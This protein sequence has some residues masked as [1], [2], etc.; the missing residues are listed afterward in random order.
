MVFCV[1]VTLENASSMQPA[2][3][4]NSQAEPNAFSLLSCFDPITSPLVGSVLVL[5]VLLV[6]PKVK[7]NCLW[8]VVG[9]VCVFAASTSAGKALRSGAHFKACVKLYVIK[10][11]IKIEGSR[12]NWQSPTTAS[13]K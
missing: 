5:T 7:D 3:L 4:T 9:M 12:V 6:Q 2:G 13:A 11:L 8:V 1:L 10:L